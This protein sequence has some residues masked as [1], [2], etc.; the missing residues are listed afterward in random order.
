[1]GYYFWSGVHV[2]EEGGGGWKFRFGGGG[3]MGGIVF[4]FSS[5]VDYKLFFG[6]LVIFLGECRILAKMWVE[7]FCLDHI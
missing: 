1:M 5:F 6:H 2:G 7:E 3:G 4:G